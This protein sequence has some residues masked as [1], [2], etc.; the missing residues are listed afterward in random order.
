VSASLALAAVALAGPP[1]GRWEGTTSQGGRDFSF[2]VT[3]EAVVKNIVFETRANCTSESGQ[4]WHPEFVTKSYKGTKGTV[5]GGE[6]HIVRDLP[7]QKYELHGKFNAGKATGRIR[8]KFWTKADGKFAY[9]KK[10][11]VWTC[12]SN[13]D[14]SVTKPD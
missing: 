4:K 14:W 8:W 6:I 9:K 13:F 5:K 11:R 1:A 7:E 10:D 2:K 12:K 3:Q